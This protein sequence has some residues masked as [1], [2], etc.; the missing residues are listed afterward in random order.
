[1][2]YSRC[3]KLHGK[4]GSDPSYHWEFSTHPPLIFLMKII[5]WNIR[6]LNGRS[7]QRL[8]HKRIMA[9]NLNIL[10]LQDT[11]CVILKVDSILARCWRQSNFMNIHSRGLTCGLDILW[12][13][14]TTILGNFFTT[15]WTILANY[16]AIGSNKEGIIS[17][18]YDPNI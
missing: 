9:E 10:L 8:L 16:R 3:W 14:T 4:L 2:A 11:K 12:N 17:N 13:S 18:V 6:G 7:K 5:S 15:K 1:M